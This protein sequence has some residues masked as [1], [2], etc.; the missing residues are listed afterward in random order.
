M[1]PFGRGL[2]RHLAALALGLAFTRGAQSAEFN[3]VL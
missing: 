3:Y 2:G 1:R